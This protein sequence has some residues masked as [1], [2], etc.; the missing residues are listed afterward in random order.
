MAAVRFVL[1]R[2]VVLLVACAVMPAVASAADYAGT[3][4][5][6]VPSGAPGSVPAPP[7]AD[8][9]AQMY[10][11]LTPLF[12]HV[13]AADCTQL[14]QARAARDVATRTPVRSRPRPCRTRA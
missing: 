1:K 14:L 4:M 9:Q 11:A 6:I 13:S 3:A 7:G 5:D 2:C 10:N 12:N 8:T